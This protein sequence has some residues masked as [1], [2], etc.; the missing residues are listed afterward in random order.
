VPAEN[1]EVRLSARLSGNRTQTGKAGRTMKL[2][3]S[4]RDWQLQDEKYVR[5]LADIALQAA[6]L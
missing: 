6:V 1:A 2:W 4:G 5:R 3:R